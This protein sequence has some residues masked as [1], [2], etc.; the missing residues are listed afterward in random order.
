[1]SGDDQEPELP[2]PSWWNMAIP[3]IIIVAAVAFAYF[4][5]V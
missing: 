1:M 5:V 3:F 4:G 2:Q